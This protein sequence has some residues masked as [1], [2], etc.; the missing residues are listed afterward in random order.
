M[1]RRGLTSGENSAFQDI[2]VDDVV[3]DEVDFSEIILKVKGLVESSGESVNEVSLRVRGRSGRY[4]LSVPFL[5]AL[6]R[7]LMVRSV[8]TSFPSFW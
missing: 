7:I 6:R 5:R 1:R 2:V 3:E 4:T 8:G